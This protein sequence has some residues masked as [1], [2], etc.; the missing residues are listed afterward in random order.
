M[1]IGSLIEQLKEDPVGSKVID[2][3]MITFA[4]QVKVI[5]D[6]R[7]IIATEK[8]MFTAGGCTALGEGLV[9]A[10][11]LVK[12][13]SKRY[14]DEGI[15]CHIPWIIVV[16]DAETTDDMTKAYEKILEEQAKGKHGH[17]KI[18]VLAV[19]GTNME[20]CH[21]ITQRVIK[22][23]DGDFKPI[24]DWTRESMLQLSDSGPGENIKHKNLPGNALPDNW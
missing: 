17:V 14:M 4:D 3:A 20:I 13:Q 1:G 24:F 22:I 21:K 16:T 23:T 5:Q 6:F 15:D 19:E 7:P 2:I 11:D 8:P 12:R 18:W 9:T 10:I